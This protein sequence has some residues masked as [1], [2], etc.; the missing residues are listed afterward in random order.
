MAISEWYQIN[1]LSVGASR[2]AD[3]KWRI[4]YDE[5][6][7]RLRV[8]TNGEAFSDRV[9]AGLDLDAYRKIAEYVVVDLNKRH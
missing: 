2:Y 5:L 1:K 3:G 6:V 9:N 4:E 8:L 7:T